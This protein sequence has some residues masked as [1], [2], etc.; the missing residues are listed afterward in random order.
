MSKTAILYGMFTPTI[1]TASMRIQ[2]KFPGTDVLA[3]YSINRTLNLLREHQKVDLV[4]MMNVSPGF[5]CEDV[6]KIRRSGYTGGLVVTSGSARNRQIQLDFA[7]LPLPEKNALLE[8]PVSREDYLEAVSR[9]LS[10]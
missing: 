7:K 6:E 4:S 10:D 1:E 8:S 2:E 3:S 5:I 9:Y